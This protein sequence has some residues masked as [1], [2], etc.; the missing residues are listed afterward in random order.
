MADYLVLTLIPQSSQIIFRR[1]KEEENIKT[2]SGVQILNLKKE[3]KEML[4]N[5]VLF[6][7]LNNAEIG[8]LSLCKRFYTIGRGWA[9]YGTVVIDSKTHVKLASFFCFLCHGG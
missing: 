4:S 8:I 9:S 5:H 7:E 3:V 6:K 2:N 1:W